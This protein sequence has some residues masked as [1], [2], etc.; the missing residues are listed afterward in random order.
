MPTQ[1][2]EALRLE[3]GRTDGRSVESAPPIGV[4][5]KQPTNERV[6]NGNNY[7]AMSAMELNI[8][9]NNCGRFI[10]EMLVRKQQ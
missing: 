2:S 9:D 10:H 4:K 3:D 7:N 5:C 8:I 6:N 1:G